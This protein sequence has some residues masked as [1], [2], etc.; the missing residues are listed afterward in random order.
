M[1]S[2]ATTFESRYETW[3]SAK[4]YVRR[5]LLGRGPMSS[6]RLVPFDVS[7]WTMSSCSIEASLRRTLAGYFR[8]YHG[9]RAHIS[10]GK[11]SP[12]PRPIQPP[13]V[14]HVVAVPQVGGLHHRY[15]RRAACTARNSTSLLPIPVLISMP[16]RV[17]VLTCSLGGP[18][19][20]WESKHACLG[21]M[22]TARTNDI[23]VRDS[24]MLATDCAMTSN[25]LSAP[26]LSP[27]R[28]ARV[29]AGPGVFS[30]IASRS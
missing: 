9:T 25:K 28:D 7:V 3:A 20:L 17:P 6:G 29:A 14:G 12:E 5:T 13:E 10:L 16:N 23:F 21:K 2:L 27:E 30:S 11:D 8:Y 15:E 18:E 22:L 24:A 19:Q 26:R 4:S 1:Q